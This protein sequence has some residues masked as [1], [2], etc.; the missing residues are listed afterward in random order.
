MKSG[1]KC[2]KYFFKATGE[3]ALSP[4]IYIINDHKQFLATSSIYFLLCV[5]LLHIR[6][7]ALFVALL[8]PAGGTGVP[9]VPWGQSRALH[10]PLSLIA[11]SAA[12][13]AAGREH[14]WLEKMDYPPQLSLFLCTKMRA[15]PL[16]APCAEKGRETFCAISS[17]GCSL[18]KLHLT[19]ARQEPSPDLCFSKAEERH[20]LW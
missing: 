15:L 11:S 10:R 1:D 18:E 3:R 19:F 12:A 7:E 20:L 6:T 14:A 9:P 13:Q 5:C 16:A 4:H 2:Y 17:H 8:F